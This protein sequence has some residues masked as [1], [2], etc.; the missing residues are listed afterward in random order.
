[1]DDEGPAHLHP[2]GNDAAEVG[3]CGSGVAIV[4]CA[5]PLGGVGASGLRSKLHVAHGTALHVAHLEAHGR[6]GLQRILHRKAA[7]GGVGVNPHGGEDC[8]L[9]PCASDKLIKLVVAYGAHVPR[10]D[11]AI[12]EVQ[13]HHIIGEGG[14]AHILQGIALLRAIGE[15]EIDALPLRGQ[16]R[17]KESECKE[18]FFHGLDIEEHKKDGPCGPPSW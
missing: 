16:G 15:T 17:G 10:I 3:A 8:R 11:R 13:V 18:V 9:S 4:A 12:G 5:V 2:W 14:L 1:M 7:R 6:I